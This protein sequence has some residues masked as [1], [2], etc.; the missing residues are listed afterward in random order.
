MVQRKAAPGAL[1]GA[2]MTAVA[3]T[4]PATRAGGSSAATSAA[5][6]AVP[7]SK[8][9]AEEVEVAKKGTAATACAASS[10][11]Q[12]TTATAPVAVREAGVASGAWAGAGAPKTAARAAAAPPPV[13]TTRIAPACVPSTTT[14][15]RGPPCRSRVGMASPSTGEEPPPRAALRSAEVPARGAGCSHAA[16]LPPLPSVPESAVVRVV[17]AA[18]GSGVRAAAAAECA[19]AACAVAGKAL[20]GGVP[21]AGDTYRAAASVTGAVVATASR[22]A[23]DRRGTAAEGSD[24]TAAALAYGSC[25]PL[26]AASADAA[27]AA[28]VVPPPSAV[29]HS[30]KLAAGPA[31]GRS[32][33]A[34]PAAR[35]ASGARGSR[36]GCSARG[37][38]SKAVVASAG[39]PALG[40]SSVH[41]L[42]PV[43]PL[44]PAVLCAS[45][46]SVS[47]TRTVYSPATPMLRTSA[48]SA[49]APATAGSG[50]RAGAEPAGAPTCSHSTRRSWDTGKAEAVAPMSSVA[51]GWDTMRAGHPTQAAARRV[52][53]RTVAVPTAPSAS[54]AGAVKAHALPRRPLTV[55]TRATPVVEAATTAGRGLPAS[56]GA[57]AEAGR[58]SAH[59]R[60]KGE[61]PV[62]KMSVASST[63]S[64]GPAAAAATRKAADAS[65]PAAGSSAGSSAAPSRPAVSRHTYRARLGTTVGRRLTYTFSVARPCR[66]VLLTT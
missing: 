12:T 62:S 49:C 23:T 8:R 53:A 4:L 25:A 52:P 5:R 37:A 15:S 11:T 24:C 41:A 35:L 19:V 60:V 32:T 44:A 39:R 56:P 61:P 66:L 18:A 34:R 47:V 63:M 46:A 29:T 54:V 40:L 58:S 26:A 55:C 21:V 51:A 22:A 17:E 13:C 65:A 42:A 43:V 30:V 9:A 2:Y 48:S 57:M 6:G 59:A 50:T 64:K 14:A 3:G 33:P 27:A 45:A 7:T 38:G 10:A 20:A 1:A 36:R 28:A 31:A 16:A